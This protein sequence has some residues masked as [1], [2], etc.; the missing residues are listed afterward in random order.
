MGILVCFAGHI[1]SGKTSISTAVGEALDWKRTS[2]GDFLRAEVTRQGGNPD[3]RQT[4]QDLGQS[5][6]A[7]GPEEFCRQVLAAGLYRADE[8]FILDGVRHVDIYLALQHLVKPT[9][10]KLIFLQ[11]EDEI[12]KQRVTARDGSPADLVRADAHP[13]E[14]DLRFNLPALAATTI[15]GAAPLDEVV[16]Q[17]LAAIRG[18]I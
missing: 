18:W 5:C 14:A 10:V 15:N 9:A 6:V 16:R 13:V 2:F 3:H 12:R 7:K 8:N 11:S 17:S 4:L 1:G